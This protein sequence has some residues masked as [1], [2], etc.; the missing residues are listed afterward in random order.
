MI[1]MSM[2]D[3]RMDGEAAAVSRTTTGLRRKDDRRLSLTAVKSL[4]RVHA[5]NEAICD[6]SESPIRN[7]GIRRGPRVDRCY[8]SPACRQRAYRERKAKGGES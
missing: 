6:S 3:G 8:C 7:V 5:L 2:R 1:A 4:L